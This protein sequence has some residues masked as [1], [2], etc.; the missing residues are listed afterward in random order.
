[1][2]DISNILSGGRSGGYNDIAQGTQE[3]QDQMRKYYEQGRSDLAP[4]R[5]AGENA[6]PQFQSDLDTINNMGHG[7]W[8]N[9][10]RESPQARYQTEHAMTS[11]NNAAA[12]TGLLGSGGNQQ[13][14]ANIANDIAS[15]DQQQFFNNEM[16]I[17]QSH[18][19]GLNNLMGYG[20]GAA[21]QS[22]T[23]SQNFAE[24]LAGLIKAQAQAQA[25]SGVANTTGKNSGITSLLS[26]L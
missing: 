10:Y 7:N 20:S 14:N 2:G 9:D 5:T 17:R 24:Q 11:M 19:G 26:L 6:I 21:G 25:S 12:A 13:E 3:A 8:M 18:M 4:W 15:K 1:M 23:Q 22:A 16:D